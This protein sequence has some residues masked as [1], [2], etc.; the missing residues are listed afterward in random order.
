ML[1]AFTVDGEFREDLRRRFVKAELE[2]FKVRYD[3]DDTLEREEFLNSREFDW[4]PVS[5]GR[6]GL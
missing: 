5:V 4:I 1:Y 2:L 6:R 3:D